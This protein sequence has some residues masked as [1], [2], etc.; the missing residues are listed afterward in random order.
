MRDPHVERLIYSIDSEGRTSFKE[1]PPLTFEH[2][3]GTFDARDGHLTVSLKEHFESEKA[4][5]HAVEEVL[6][7]WQ[8]QSDLDL[9]IGTIRFRF[10]R[11][12]IID[13]N[14]P[15]P[16]TP[17]ELQSAMLGAITMSGTATLSIQ[18]ARYP[19]PPTAFRVS[20]DL[21]TA[22]YRWA[23]FRSERE[24]LPSVAY[25]I[26]TVL[27]HAA[28]R[29]GATPE[30]MFA[31]HRD[32]LKTVSKLA[33]WKGDAKTARKAPKSGAYEELS[34]AERA[35][36]EAA[37]VRLVKRLGEHAAGIPL[38]KLMMSDLPKLP[39]PKAGRDNGATPTRP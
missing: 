14:P 27:K 17:M 23:Q 25:F 20:P 21:A 11:C 10:L 29:A 30:L 1:P 9:D 38:P 35:W 36:L 28:E 3:L 37:I 13:R 8:I 26:F 6:Q 12:D 7:A 32:V 19:P 5:R 16:G 39:K 2:P 22:H 24:Q 4:A 31:I 33:S 15:P 18:R 34:G